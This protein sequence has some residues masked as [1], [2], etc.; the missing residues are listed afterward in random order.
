LKII[1]NDGCEV[2]IN[3]DHKSIYIRKT[4]DFNDNH[5]ML[6]HALKELLGE[7]GDPSF[8]KYK[9]W[10]RAQTPNMDIT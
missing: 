8:H 7:L 4:D 6:K 3:D 9:E 5:E 10:L 2:F 1:R